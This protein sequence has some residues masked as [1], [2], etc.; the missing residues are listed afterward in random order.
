MPPKQRTEISSFSPLNDFVRE[1]KDFIKHARKCAVV[2]TT[3]SLRKRVDSLSA[4]LSYLT[5][6][7]HLTTKRDYQRALDR[8]TPVSRND[9]F[10]DLNGLRDDTEHGGVWLS[11]WLL[12]PPTPAK[13][14]SLNKGFKL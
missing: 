1:A 2:Q 8:Y 13:R 6:K 3:P 12:L 9:I 14:K 4:A 11:A 10:V 5:Q 7:K